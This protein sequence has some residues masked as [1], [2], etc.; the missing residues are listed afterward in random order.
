MDENLQEILVGAET[1]A[2]AAFQSEYRGGLYDGHFDV[3]TDATGYLKLYGRADGA[4]FQRFKGEFDVH[5][6]A[7][8]NHTI[9]ADT[10][11]E[12]VEIPIKD[13]EL[14]LAWLGQNFGPL[15]AEAATNA[16][17]LKDELITDLIKDAI[18]TSVTNA[19][20][21]ND[22][23]FF[24]ELTLPGA[25]AGKPA[26]KLVNRCAASARTA[27]GIRDAF[28]KAKKL[29][30]TMKK[31]NGKPYHGGGVFMEGFSLMFPTSLEQTVNE[32]FD[33][34]RTSSRDSKDKI[35]GVD[36]RENNLW[37]AEGI[38]GLLLVP[39]RKRGMGMFQVVQRT[40]NPEFFSD[41]PAENPGNFRT[42]EQQTKLKYTAS[43]TLDVEVG[44]GNPYAGVWIDIPEES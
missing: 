23:T 10:F 15:L 30:S 40:N 43:A 17:H 41:L 35:M 2:V 6:I 4:G 39:K 27:T 1:K 16:A 34:N 32:V 11:G 22:S 13:W 31:P 7:H 42:A 26:G 3:E 12:V 38:N 21:F 36:T 9:I 5:R 20:L 28:Y 19:N 14:L 29:L 33:N 8:R 44:L 37:D 24:G 25:G 18:D